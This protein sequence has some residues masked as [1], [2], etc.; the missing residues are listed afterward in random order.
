MAFDRYNKIFTNAIMIYYRVQRDSSFK[1]I[2][3]SMNMTLAIVSFSKSFNIHDHK[4]LKKLHISSEV[5]LENKQ[6]SFR[7]SKQN[8]ALQ[9]SNQIDRHY[10]FKRR[11][12]K[13]Y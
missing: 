3:L 1:N 12:G 4:Y 9:I 6:V 5:S 10:T 13:C 7:S 2:G 8:I 11:D